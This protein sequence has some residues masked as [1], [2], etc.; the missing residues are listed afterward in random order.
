MKIESN[1]PKDLQK[2]LSKVLNGLYN[3]EDLNQYRKN[4]LGIAI[5]DLIKIINDVEVI[6]WKGGIYRVVK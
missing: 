4:K 2:Q 6:G 5:N 3:L 1:R